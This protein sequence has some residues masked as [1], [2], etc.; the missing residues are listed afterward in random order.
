[1]QACFQQRNDR[2]RFERRRR[3][4]NIE[5][6]RNRSSGEKEDGCHREAAQ[7]QHAM[8]RGQARLGIIDCALRQDAFGPELAERL[9][10]L[11][12]HEQRHREAEITHAQDMGESGIA[13]ERENLHG[14]SAGEHQRALPQNPTRG[15]RF[16]RTGG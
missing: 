4:G 1:M 7:H 9:D 12:C 16:G 3:G 2:E 14:D 13:R 10:Q 5:Q 6:S 11:Q 8:Q 15:E